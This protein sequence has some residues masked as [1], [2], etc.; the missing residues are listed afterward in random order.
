MTATSKPCWL[1][2]RTIVVSGLA[3]SGLIVAAIVIFVVSAGSGQNV[4]AQASDGQKPATAGESEGSGDPPGGDRSVT[5]DNVITVETIH[6]KRN[7]QGFVHSEKQPAYVE[8]YFTAD[9]MAR[10]PGTVKSI[11]KN[12]GDTVTEGEVLVELDAPDLVQELTQKKAA[13]LNAEQ[14]FKAAQVNLLV[15]QACA[16]TARALVK[17][18]EAAEAHAAAL[19]KFHEEEFDR[20][21]L[22]AQRDAV[23]ATVLDEKL[24]DLE[25]AAADYQTAQAATDTA[26]AKAEEFSAKV[27]AAR[28][29]I[30]VKRAKVTFAEADRDHAQAMVDFTK[31]RAPFNGLI[32]SRK[33]DPGSF[34]Q[35]ASTGNPT[36]MLRVVRTD[37][38]TLVTWMPEKDAPFV[39]KNTEAIIQLNALEDQEIH[40][41]VTR[42]SHWLDPDKWRDMRVEVDFDNKD[43]RLK[44]GMYGDMT[45]LLEDFSQSRLVPAGAVV[46]SANHSYIFEVRDGRAIR[47]P[48]RVQYEDGVQA[49]I[50]KVV[51]ST[52]PK[53]GRTV[54][55]YEELTDQDEIVRSGQGE[56]ADGQPVKTVAAIGRT[57]AAGLRCKWC[58]PIMRR[59]CAQGGAYGAR[60]TAPGGQKPDAG[61]LRQCGDA[62]FLPRSVDLPPCWQGVRRRPAIP[63]RQIRPSPNRAR[64]RRLMESLGPSSVLSRF[65][66]PAAWADHRMSVS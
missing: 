2:K 30:D 58:C 38:V 15:A 34:V 19:K 65:Q 17:E 8:G 16:K 5:G 31:I 39:N 21:K 1:G 13:V 27:D 63:L 18:S 46:A 11:Q 64:H 48:V 36:P 26:K 22:L 29:D 14:D 50:V 62:D 44:P 55:K 10:V 28:V 60:Q 56:L 54:E 6:P 57:V 4:A 43:G 49:K 12:I 7:P 51:R 66:R 52:D 41:K 33:V 61:G 53:T 25:A 59:R 45:L 32:V 42:Y 9:L 3:A 35:N 37:I 47:V 23:V 20:Y 40:T 24:R